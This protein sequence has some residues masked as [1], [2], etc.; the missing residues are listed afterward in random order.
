MAGATR[1]WSAIAA[2]LSLSVSSVAIAQQAQPSAP[3]QGSTQLPPIVV[4]TTKAPERKAAQTKAKASTKAARSKAR[5]SPRPVAV[6]TPTPTPTAPVAEVPPSDGASTR[7]G[8]VKGYV[9]NEVSAVT[10]TSTPV[11]EVPQSLTTVTRAQ[12]EDRKPYSLEDVM[13]YVPG[14]RVNGA[15]FDPR[16][17]C[18]NIRG[19]DCSSGDSLFRDG[20][21]QMASPFGVFRNEIYGLDSLTVLRGPSSMIYGAS[22]AGGILDMYT[23]RPTAMPFREVEFLIGNHERFQGNF[24]FSGPIAPGS[25]TLYRLTGVVRDS[26]TQ[27]LGVEDDRFYIAPSFTFKPSDS[28]KVTVF[29]E[30]MKSNA[31]GNMAYWNDYNGD[32]VRRTNIVSGDPNFND[33]NQE[34]WRVGY[35]VEHR[36]NGGLTL[37]QKARYAGLNSKL[38]YIDIAIP[39]DNDGNALPAVG[40][41]GPTGLPLNGIYP[42]ATGTLADNMHTA[43]MDNNA[44][45]KFATGPLRHT[46]LAGVDL[47]YLTYK[48]AEGFETDDIIY[49]VNGN[50]QDIVIGSQVP[51]LVNFNYGASRIMDPPI[52]A[53]TSQDLF[54]T[55]VYLQDQIKLERWILTLGARHDWLETKTTW[56]DLAGTITTQDKKDQKWSGRVALGYGFSS[57]LTPYIAYATSFSPTAGTSPPDADTQAAFDPSTAKS[58]E[59]GFKYLPP[60]MNILIAGSLFDIE[61]QNGLVAETF[62]RDGVQLSRL[63]QTGILNSRGGEI[64]AAATFGGWNFLASYSYIDMEIVDGGDPTNNGN[65]LSSIPQHTAS[66]WA[67]YSF[68]Y[69]MLTGFGLGAGVRY[70][71]E[72]FG[73]D[74]NTFKNEDRTLFDAAAHYD[75][76]SIDQRFKGARLQLNVSNIFDTEKDICQAD[77]CYRD[78]GRAVLGSLRYRW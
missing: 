67:G 28:T 21:R 71:G 36:V 68:K 66:L 38:E 49:D 15:G 41:L 20:L 27:Q 30:Y 25:S 35:E 19:F 61:Q 56:D 14:T 9:A 63:V 40:P 72:S 51:P 16:F 54:S 74:E 57:G 77:Y 58:K 43:V 46:V 5:P 44:E 34:Q 17:D 18:V 78:K 55:G 7:L 37:R 4:E 2:L 50:P 73:N 42:R 47:S 23:K 10:K 22:S 65:T 76:A 12:L 59:I 75:L 13:S 8:S 60:G 26:E 31:G 69:G 6:T 62:E 32:H 48:E 29:G 33:F 11:T 24:D 52:I 3:S 53:R 45:M 39:T 64:E 70:I 1:L